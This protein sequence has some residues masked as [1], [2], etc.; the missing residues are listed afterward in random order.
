MFIAAQFT[1]AQCWKQHKCPSVNVCTKKLL[2]IYTMEYFT[3][4]G[5]KDLL[6]FSTGGVELESIMLTEI[7]QVV[8]DKCHMISPGS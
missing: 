7:S 3:A 8:K 6:C 5:K 1:V 4:E 2:Y